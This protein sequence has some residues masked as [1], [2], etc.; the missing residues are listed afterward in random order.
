[1]SD[2]TQ[3]RMDAL[4]RTTAGAVLADFLRDRLERRTRELLQ[5][6]EK[7]FLAQQGRC[8]ELEDLLNYI[9]EGKG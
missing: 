4:R 2:A 7:T 8:R 5:C 1:M 9:T 3:Q 6:T